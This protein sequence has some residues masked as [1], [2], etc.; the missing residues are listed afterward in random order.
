MAQSSRIGPATRALV[1]LVACSANVLSQADDGDYECPFSCFNL[2]SQVFPCQDLRGS[3]GT[4]YKCYPPDGGLDSLGVQKCDAALYD[5]RSK[6]DVPEGAMCAGCKFGSGP[7]R[8][9]RNSE[10]CRVYDYL[11]DPPVCPSDYIACIDE[12]TTA[13]A[14]TVTAT[15][16]TATTTTTGSTTTT[17]GTSTTTIRQCEYESIAGW[18][19]CV[20]EIEGEQII[21]FLAMPDGECI[22][23]LFDCKETTTTTTT[24]ITATSTTTNAECNEPC[25]SGTWGDCRN[26]AEELG[27]TAECGAPDGTHNMVE[28]QCHSDTTMDCRPHSFTSTYPASP[29]TCDATECESFSVNG[30]ALSADQEL[31][32]VR[33]SFGHCKHPKTGVCL[34]YQDDGGCWPGTF[35]CA[36]E[37]KCTE[38]DKKKTCCS[39][40]ATEKGETSGPCKHLNTGVC[41]DYIRN[42]RDCF[43]GTEAC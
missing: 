29:F 39:C 34:P 35:S 20:F 27:G 40:V 36:E 22:D 21:R 25:A 15:T 16:V 1:A 30:M 32:F 26:P 2:L 28:A 43:P 31:L 5:C 4:P 12:T 37:I 10:L 9:L 38:A 18:G 11:Q 33:G 41:M 13:T 14:T 23:G 17:T 7:C 8:D 6:P 3:I 19:P 24:S 42:T